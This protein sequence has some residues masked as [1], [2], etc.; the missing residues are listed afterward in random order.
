MPS[1]DHEPQVL[2]EVESAARKLTDGKSPG[3]DSIKAEELKAS[4]DTRHLHLTH[5]ALNQRWTKD[6]F[7]A[8][9]GNNAHL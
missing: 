2:R 3:H 7:P 6:T 4:G 1:L 8:D 5:T 9:W